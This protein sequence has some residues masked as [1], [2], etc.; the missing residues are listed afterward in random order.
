MDEYYCTNCQAILNEQPGFRPSLKS[1][2]CK[3]CGMLLVDEEVYDGKRFKGVAWFCDNCGALLNRQRRFSDQNA[4]WKCTKC[5]YQ[6][7]IT[8]EDI[9]NNDV[10]RCPECDAILDNQIGFSTRKKVWECTCC[11]TILCNDG[12]EYHAVPCKEDNETDHNEETVEDDAVDDGPQCPNC[13]SYLN[14]QWGYI[15]YG[16]DWVCK[17]C[18]AKLHRDYSCD[19]YEA[20]CEDDDS[21]EGSRCPECGC[22]LSEQSGYGEY[23]DDWECEECGAQLHRDYS[24]ESYEVIYDN[25]EDDEDDEDDD[26]EADEDDIDTGTAAAVVLAALAKA[27]ADK[28]NSSELARKYRK[29]KRIKKLLAWRFSILAVVVLALLLQGGYYTLQQRIPMEYSFESLEG[30]EYQEAVQVLKDTGYKKVRA[31]EV[32]DLPLSRESEEN[33]VTDVWMSWG[34]LFNDD[35]KYPIHLPVIVEYHT[36]KLFNPPIISK[37]AKGEN[38]RKI[39]KKFEDAG[40]TNIT[41]QVE[42]DLL[43]GWIIDDGAV[44]SITIDGDKNYSYSDEY[45][46]DVEVVITY[47]ALRNEK[48]SA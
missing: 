9:I 21:D 40:F 37:D 6:N 13:D 33:I 16:Y 4:T 17:E 27:A 10:L 19:P 39:V 24:F 15:D 36:I 38:Y 41:V 48:P 25:D 1:W 30:L 31:K 34:W 8:E 5:G 3:E 18:G 45:R 42:Y 14:K 22:Y 47:D 26:E 11:N 29:K 28:Y 43:T 20:V 44:K 35:T 7:G 2:K 23:Q 46:S 32:A 12:E